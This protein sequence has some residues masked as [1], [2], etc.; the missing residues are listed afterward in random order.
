MTG[1]RDRQALANTRTRLDYHAAVRILN[2]ATGHGWSQ[3]VSIQGSDDEQIRITVRISLRHQGE[4][5]RTG[6]WS[7]PRR[8]YQQIERSAFVNAVTAFR[9]I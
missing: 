1:S 7:G 3:Q 4:T 5:S 2:Y 8:Q 9:G 6:S